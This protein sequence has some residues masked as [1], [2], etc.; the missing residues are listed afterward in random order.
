MTTLHVLIHRTKRTARFSGPGTFAAKEEIKQ[1][2]SARFN[3][4][5]KHWEVQGL[6]VTVEELTARFPGIVIEEIGE[7]GAGAPERAGSPTLEPAPALPP[8]VPSGLSVSQFLDRAR[9]ALRAAFP[10]TVCIYGVLSDVNR[11]AGGRIFMELNGGPETDDRIKCVIW[12][13]AE[14]KLAKLRAAG[15]DLEPELQVMFEVS[16]NLNKRGGQLSLSVERVIAEYTIGKLAALREQTNER[17]K[18]EGLFDKNRSCSL[19]FLPRRL[20]ILTSA[21]GTVIND[22]LA[23]LE[24]GRFG[25]ELFW[26]NVSVQGADAKRSVLAGLAALSRMPDLD[27]ILIFRGGGSQSELAVFNDYDI[28]RAV[29]LCPLPVISAIGHQEDQCSVQDVSWKGLGVPKDVGR[30]FADIV[31]GYRER[32]R[33]A[34]TYISTLTGRTVTQLERNLELHARSV[35]KFLSQLV[36]TREESCRRHEES[37]PLLAATAVRTSFLRFLERSRPL[38]ALGL[39]TMSAGVAALGRIGERLRHDADRVVERAEHR[40]RRIGHLERE[41][42]RVI[43]QKAARVNAYGELF[44]S[45]GPDTQ[46]KRGFA[47]VQRGDRGYVTSGAGLASGE[48][49][50]IIFHDTH[51]KAEIK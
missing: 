12:D 17:L 46:L 50:E 7:G 37:L 42:G 33:G 8:G 3:R 24:V 49:V 20:G 15:F 21:G 44:E 27:A 18:K 1:L 31:V 34:V 13:N 19:P 29:C 41:L 16:V 36:S 23:S 38:A 11:A 5:E 35:L 51:R 4:E 32:F 47:L 10:G 14:V 45:L 28:A 43:E 40:F 25:F 39:S 2:G 9:V 26:M 48:E 30:F 22:F 6:S